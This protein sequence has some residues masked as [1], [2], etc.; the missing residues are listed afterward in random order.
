MTGTYKGGRGILSMLAGNVAEWQHHRDDD[1]ANWSNYIAYYQS[2]PQ[3]QE[4]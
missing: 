1:K 2:L 4:P 3:Q